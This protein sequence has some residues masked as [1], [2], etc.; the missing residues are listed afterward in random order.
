MG[1]FYLVT[2]TGSPIQLPARVNETK[3]TFTQI[4]LRGA[5][6]VRLFGHLTKDRIFL[7]DT[8]PTRKP[9]T[10]NGSPK[11]KPFRP[12]SDSAASKPETKQLGPIRKT[13]RKMERKNGVDEFGNPPPLPPMTSSVQ[14]KSAGSGSVLN[15]L[16]PVAESPTESLED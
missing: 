4:V 15:E 2:L 9:K 13:G 12:D 1:D 8:S 10:M 11:R 6:L 3:G 16:D 14:K 7:A 5:I